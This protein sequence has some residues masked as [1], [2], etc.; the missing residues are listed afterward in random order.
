MHKP[1]VSVLRLALPGLLA[2][3][4]LTGATGTAIALSLPAA[5]ELAIIRPAAAVDVPTTVEPIDDWT[6]DPRLS[7]PSPVDA[8]PDGWIPAAAPQAVGAPVPTATAKVESRTTTRGAKP[9]A[10]TAPAGSSKPAYRGRNHIWIPSLG[11]S[12]DLT[13]FPCS[14]STP[15]GHRLY[16]WGC[17]GHNNVYVFAHAASVFGPLHNAYVSGRLKKGMR[18]VYADG[19]GR[20]RT[21]KVRFWKV[22]SPVGSGW[23]YAAQS[24]PSMTLQTCVGSRSQY[25]LV[26]RLT[27]A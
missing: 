16:R 4:L 3:A 17:A 8:R 20:V 25:R 22:V 9:T 5:T 6:N 19:N 27:A 21:Y 18:V 14:R 13:W 23:A 15:P 1:R 2:A 11:L 24:T 26:V 7:T 12:R 10:S